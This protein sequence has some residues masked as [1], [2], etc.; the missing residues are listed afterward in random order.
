M[1]AGRDVKRIEIAPRLTICV[2]SDGELAKESVKLYAA[3]LLG[4]A[5]TSG[6]VNR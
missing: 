4:T 3:I 2:S 1:R 6:Y 5:K